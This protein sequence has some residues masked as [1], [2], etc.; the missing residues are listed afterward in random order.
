MDLLIDL[1]GKDGIWIDG[2]NRVFER[3]EFARLKFGV[4]VKPLTRTDLSRLKASEIGE[5]DKDD[6]LPKVFQSQVIDWDLKDGDG[7]PIVFSE[8]N[9]GVLI[10]QVPGFTNLVAQACFAAQIKRAE[11]IE[12]EVK[13]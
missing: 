1:A 11:Q 10:E 5:E 6:L 12:E 13:N 7:K 8:Y 3:T 9:K 4:K 2:N